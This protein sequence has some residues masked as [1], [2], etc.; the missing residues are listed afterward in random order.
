M[1]TSVTLAL[2]PTPEKR[3]KKLEMVSTKHGPYN[4]KFDRNH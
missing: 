2:A 1:V 4:S 3:E